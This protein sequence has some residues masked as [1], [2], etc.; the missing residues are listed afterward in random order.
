MDISDAILLSCFTDVKVSCG[1]VGYNKM[2]I[3]KLIKK[4]IISSNFS[5]HIGFLGVNLI[6]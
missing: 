6:S 5:S 3:C 4:K 2:Y 1:P